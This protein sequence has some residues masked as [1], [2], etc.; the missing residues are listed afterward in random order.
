MSALTVKLLALSIHVFASRGYHNL[1]NKW[2]YVSLCLLT[3][4]QEFK[5]LNEDITNLFFF[6]IT[7]P[8]SWK[9][10]H[11]GTSRLQTVWSV[12]SHHPSASTRP[13]DSTTGCLMPLYDCSCKPFWEEHHLGPM[14]GV[15]WA[16]I[17]SHIQ[18]SSTA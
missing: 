16:L 15:H 2:M 1:R 9:N 11:S 8:L 10:N 12:P 7:F 6:F 17:N 13:R 4:T 5:K 14:L 18:C 3:Y